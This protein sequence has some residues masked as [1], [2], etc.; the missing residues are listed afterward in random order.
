[1]NKLALISLILILSLSCSVA[2]AVVGNSQDTTV[3]PDVVT[4]SNYSVDYMDGATRIDDEN[5]I[6]LTFSTPTTFNTVVLKEDGDVIREFRFYYLN[7]V[8]EKKFI[9]KQDLVEGYR[10]C[11]FERIT[12]TKFIV[13]IKGVDGEKWDIADISIREKSLMRH[14]ACSVDLMYWSIMPES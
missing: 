4:Y 10:Y 9:Y 13:E 2:I 3:E 7:E 12:T 14:T 11:S 1:M 5:G 8:G 6:T